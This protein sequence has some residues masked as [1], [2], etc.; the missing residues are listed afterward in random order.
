[1]KQSVFIIGL[2]VAAMVVATVIFFYFVPQF[3]RDGGYLVI[4]LIALSIMVFTFIVERTFSIRKAQGKGSIPKF[5]KEVE[6]ALEA[7]D[8]TS[9]V[10]LCDRQSGS[11]ANILKNGFERYIELKKRKKPV[12]HEKLVSEVQRAIEEATGLEMP[13]LEKNL[14]ATMIGLLGTVLG[15]IRSFQA[16]ATTGAPDAVQLS[17]GISEAL[18]NTAG[19]LIAA[20]AGIIGYNVFINKVDNFT[21]M[22]DE[23]VFNVVQILSVQEEEDS[24][25]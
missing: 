5:L 4:A 1:M 16:L 23:A 8:F 9:A 17:L 10:Q 13:L 6:K 14:I 7:D 19:G 11:I 22:L 18:I 21:Y 25:E 3:I 24:H 20:I 2:L 15:M 12:P